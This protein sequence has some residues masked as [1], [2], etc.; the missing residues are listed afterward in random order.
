MSQTAET[1]RKSAERIQAFQYPADPDAPAPTGWAEWENNLVPDDGQSP[2][3]AAPPAFEQ[4]LAEE[5]RRAFESGCERGRQEGRQAE[6][7]AQGAALQ[8]A[9]EQMLRRATVLVENFAAE[10]DR[11][12]LAAEHEVVKLA[13]AIAARILRREA[14]MD[15][16]LLTG[17]ARVA[18]GQLSATTEIR[19]RVPSADL[20][21]WTEAMAV[22]PNLPLRPSV[23]G[24]DRLRLGDCVLETGLGT[25]D[26]GI[27]AQ[28]AEI[29]RGFFDRAGNAARPLF[30]ESRAEGDPHP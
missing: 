5:T 9:Q 20:E 28:L 30:A 1:S 17:A 18:L 13:L 23:V 11:Y 14:Q 19:L 24:E 2:A 22:I 6:R 26:L 4:R 27:R 7:A 21:L 3:Q 16:L 25:V 10:R 8:A 15:P 29:E 12:L